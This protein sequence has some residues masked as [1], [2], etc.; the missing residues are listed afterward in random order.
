MPMS[1][2]FD[3]VSCMPF[4]SDDVIT[5]QFSSFSEIFLCL[6]QVEGHHHSA[7]GM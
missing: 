2:E 7:L 4:E 3:M 1:R 5:Y 6:A